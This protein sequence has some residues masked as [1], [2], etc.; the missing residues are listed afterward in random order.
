MRYIRPIIG[1]DL[2]NTIAIYDKLFRNQA[3]LLNVPFKFKSKKEI[4]DYLRDI[5]SEEEWTKL[6]GLIYGPLMEYAEVADGFLDTLK[7]LIDDNFEIIIISHRT[8]YSQYDGLYNLHYFANKWI[9]KNI[10]SKIGKNKIKN[11]IFAETIDSKVNYISIENITYFIDDLPKV[12]N[13]INFPKTVKKILYSNEK[14]SENY[15]LQS[16]NWIE[17]INFITK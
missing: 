6:Q 4:A 12:L 13:H 1:I 7:K 3:N 5:D 11:I 16:N 9:E 10:I 2:D 8:Q 14:V 15:F 17:L